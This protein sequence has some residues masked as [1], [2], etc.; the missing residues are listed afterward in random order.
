MRL[1]NYK[2]PIL[3]DGPFMVYDRQGLSDGPFWPEHLEQSTLPGKPWVIA[4]GG[5]PLVFK[6]VKQRGNVMTL[7]EGEYTVVPASNRLG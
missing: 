6:I 2:K 1:R 7:E 3:P 4:R 5:S